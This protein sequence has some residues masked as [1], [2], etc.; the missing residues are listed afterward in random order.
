MLL[1]AVRAGA[2]QAGER[3]K[4]SG[5]RRVETKGN[6]CKKNGFRAKSL[7]VHISRSS[8]MLALLLG[9]QCNIP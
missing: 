2:M 3:V 9:G 1:L 6:E 8:I 5:K 4:G 7:L